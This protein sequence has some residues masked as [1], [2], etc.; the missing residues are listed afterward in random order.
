MKQKYLDNKL[1]LCYM[2]MDLLIYEIETNDFYE[3]IANEVESRFDTSGYRDKPVGK[4]K[5]VIGLMKDELGGD[6]MTEFVTLRPKTYSY[7]VGKEELK[8]CKGTKK[9][10]MW[11]TISLK[12]YKN[13]LLDGTKSYR[14]QLMFRS[15][16][17][18]VRTLEVN[19]L[20]LSRDDGKRITIDGVASFTKGHWA[21]R[22]GPLSKKFNPYIK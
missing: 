6:I 18:N 20:A 19:K 12:D 14:S 9:C 8:K 4:N 7:R 10:I 21:T 22:V 11:K 3:D 17:H 13:C 1:K 15:S 2:D 5:K 16:A